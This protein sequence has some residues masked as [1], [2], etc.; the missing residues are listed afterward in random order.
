MVGR[1]GNVAEA[2]PHDRLVEIMARYGRLDQREP[3]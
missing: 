3:S 1:D 2:I